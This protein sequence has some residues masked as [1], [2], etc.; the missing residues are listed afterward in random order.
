MRKKIMKTKIRLNKYILTG[1]IVIATITSCKKD[2]LDVNENPNFPE[3]ATIEV[4]LPSAE[5]ALTHGTANP[6]GIYT[7]MYAQYW[8]QT[9]AA[10][11]YKTLE[12]YN[13][14][15]D[16]FDRVWLLFYTNALVN[17]KLIV[18]KG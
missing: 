17:L 16:D 10:S 8:T 12:Q 18:D 9:P 6:L 5:L 4:L 2:Y 1:A 15:A 14:S 3:E 7:S 13:P 11:Q